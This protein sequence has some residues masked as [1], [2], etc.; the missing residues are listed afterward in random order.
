VYQVDTGYCIQCGLCVEACPFQALFLG[1]SYERAKYRRGELVQANDALLVSKERPASGYMY[2]DI[3]AKLPPQ[4][5][6]IE[7]DKVKD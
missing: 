2:P 5:L 3:A 7:K 6:L 1:Y 4:S